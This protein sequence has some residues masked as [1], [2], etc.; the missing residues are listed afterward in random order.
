MFAKTRTDKLLQRLKKITGVL[1]LA[2]S[3]LAN[4]TFI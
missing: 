1:G 3:F 4:V 2:C